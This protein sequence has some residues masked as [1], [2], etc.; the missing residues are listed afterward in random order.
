MATITKEY[1]HGTNFGTLAL[2]QVRLALLCDAARV[3]EVVRLQQLFEITDSKKGT[4]TFV[5]CVFAHFIEM[6]ESVQRAFA[7]VC[8]QTASIFVESSGPMIREQVVRHRVEKL[9]N[10][11]LDA[12]CELPLRGGGGSGART[13]HVRGFMEA[14][15]QRLGVDAKKPCAAPLSTVLTQFPCCTVRFVDQK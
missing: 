2:N 5:N 8:L 13:F 7:Q 1:C 12:L 14:L 6:Y 3:G 15:R 4:G 10:F 9:V 11:D